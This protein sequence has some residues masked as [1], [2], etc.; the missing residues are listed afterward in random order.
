M[1]RKHGILL[2]ED[3]PYYFLSFTGLGEDPVSRKRPKSYFNL[4]QEDASTWGT[5]RVLRF[6][7]FSKVSNEIS[8]AITSI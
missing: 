4:E 6:D 2:L 1:V 7:S 5:G 8:L 3:D